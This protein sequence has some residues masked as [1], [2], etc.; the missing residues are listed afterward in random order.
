MPGPFGPDPYGRMGPPLPPPMH[1]DRDRERD[2]LYDRPNPPRPL[3]PP[4]IPERKREPLNAPTARDSP[5][6]NARENARENWGEK[7][8]VKEKMM[9]M[10]I[11]VVNR[12]QK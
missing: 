11:I 10:E 12:Q 3:T 5:R 6:E 9:D 4:D 2:I 7:P 1:R 8:N